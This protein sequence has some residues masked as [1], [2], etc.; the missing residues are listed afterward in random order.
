MNNVIN[1]IKKLFIINNKDEQIK[2]CS[3]CGWSGFNDHFDLYFCYNYD[4]CINWSAWK[5]KQNE[6]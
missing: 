6:Q 5:E 2:D 1:C 4:E 3:T